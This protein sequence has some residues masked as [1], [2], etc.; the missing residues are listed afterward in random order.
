MKALAVALV[1]WCVPNP[2]WWPQAMPVQAF[3]RILCKTHESLRLFEAI[4]DKAELVGFTA[5][6]RYIADVPRERAFLH[7]AGKSIMKGT[8]AILAAWK[9]FH[10]DQPLTIVSSSRFKES[11]PG[12]RYLDWLDDAALKSEQNRNLFYLAPSQ[13]EGYGHSLHEAASCGAVIARSEWSP[14]DEVPGVSMHAEAGRPMRLARTC[15]VSSG[16]IRDAVES[17]LAMDG[18]QIVALRAK[19]RESYVRERAAFES[20]FLHLLATI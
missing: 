17:C 16:A 9:Q 2:E 8:D 20:R 10:I 12:V 1:R 13:T 19:T 3:D 15:R 7:V 14:M 11:I 5:R 18:G 6:D 4:T